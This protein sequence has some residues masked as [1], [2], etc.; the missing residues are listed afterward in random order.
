MT[1]QDKYSNGDYQRAVGEFV[2]KHVHQCAS[3]LVYNLRA[4]DA[5]YEGDYSSDL[6]D[7]TGSWDWIDPAAWFIQ[8]EMDVDTFEMYFGEYKEVNPGFVLTPEMATLGGRKDFIESV[9]CQDQGEAEAFC[10]EFQLEPR[11][12][13]AY[14]HWIISNDLAHWLQE[15]D[16]M[17]T[18][19]FFGLTIWGRATTGQSISMDRVICDIFDEL[20][21]DWKAPVPEHKQREALAVIV[22]AAESW[23][24]ELD[25]HIIGYSSDEE[26]EARYRQEYE[27]IKTA[28]ETLNK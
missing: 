2:E 12:V 24:E 13:E 25:I 10:D 1:N 14:E 9:V 7:I 19:D 3:T 20:N 5:V 26:E 18:Y 17:V 22:S 15:Q 11:A 27:G 21:P 23:V 8:N 16:E 4:V 6:D 28:L